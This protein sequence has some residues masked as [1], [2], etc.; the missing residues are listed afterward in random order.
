MTTAGIITML[1]SIGAVWTLLICCTRRLLSK[2]SPATDAPSH[3]RHKASHH[4]S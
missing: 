4:A 2:Q 1:L 3:K